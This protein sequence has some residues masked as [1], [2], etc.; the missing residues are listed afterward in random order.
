MADSYDE[1]NGMFGPGWFMFFWPDLIGASTST[2]DADAKYEKIKERW[3]EQ[4]R[5]VKKQVVE[6]PLEIEIEE[7]VPEIA[8]PVLKA[9]KKEIKVRQQEI[10][11]TTVQQRAKPTVDIKA[12]LQQLI[13]LRD[14]IEKRQKQREADIIFVASVLATLT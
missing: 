7:V 1:S 3:R 5:K 9:V 14:S 6:A 10:V 13:E 8:A 12:E 4:L 11:T 2:S